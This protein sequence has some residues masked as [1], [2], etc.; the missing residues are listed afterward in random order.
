[1]LS[2]WRINAT[3]FTISGKTA[4]GEEDKTDR[5]E[6]VWAIVASL[7]IIMIFVVCAWIILRRIINRI[8][9]L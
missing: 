5:H 4:A 6:W 8:L 1:M 7:L 3:A 2:N 9:G